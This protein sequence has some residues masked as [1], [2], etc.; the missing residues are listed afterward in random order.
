MSDLENVAQRL[1]WWKSPSEALKD[2]I[3]FLAQVMTY[4]TWRT[5]W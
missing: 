3:C 1:F 4:G 2:P 5:S